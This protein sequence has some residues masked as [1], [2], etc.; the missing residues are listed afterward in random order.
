MLF[1][2]VWGTWFPYFVL[3]GFATFA[4][5]L[6]LWRLKRPLSI[7]LLVGPVFG[8][9]LVLLVDQT[10]TPTGRAD[11]VILIGA[12][13]VGSLLAAWPVPFGRWFYRASREAERAAK[14][15]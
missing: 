12:C 1:D 8:L 5:T 4:L 3:S 10:E 9:A 13:V 14:S 15:V 7:A 6:A 11:R 2:S